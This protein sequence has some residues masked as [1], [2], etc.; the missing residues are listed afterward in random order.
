[1]ERFLDE[2]HLVVRAVQVDAVERRVQGQLGE[3]LFGIMCTAGP[4]GDRKSAR[5]LACVRCRETGTF[6]VHEEPGYRVERSPTGGIREGGHRG[7]RE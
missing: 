2:M 1:M 4:G 5:S 3:E 6:N 7:R